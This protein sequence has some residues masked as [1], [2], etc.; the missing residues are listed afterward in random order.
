M[1]A[2]R[3]CSAT[4]VVS[5]HTPLRDA[6]RPV[7]VLA[8]EDP[9]AAV[10]DA[11]RA[12]D[13]LLL[14]TSGTSGRPRGV[15]RTAASWAASFP[16]VTSL[17]GLTAASR[18]WVPGPLTATM[19][20]FAAVHG[21]HV[22]AAAVDRPR[23]ATHA[24]LTPAALDRS[25]ADPLPVG[26]TVLVAG[27]GLGTRLHDRAAAAGLRVAH[28]YG[29]AELSFVAWGSHSGDLR[30]FPGVEVRARDGVLW[31]RSPYLARGYLGDP[32]PFEI[33]PDGFGTVGDLGTV[34]HG[35]VTVHGRGDDAITTAG[36]T[37]LVA[38][39]ERVL[40]PAAAG[41]LV[42]VAAPHPA[43]GAVVACVLTDRS[44]Q[45]RLAILARD[46]LAPA[47]RPRLWF[48]LPRLPVGPHGKVD[49]PAVRQLVATGA[50]S[51]MA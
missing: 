18:I 26:A 29:A 27:D 20:L 43:L 38:D 33:G 40:G 28:Y 22:G 37:V 47:P 21:A 31:V 2:I 7:D 23:D 10:L 45:R 8:A 5:G 1:P 3:G 14:R 9:V 51:R 36:T 12:G 41:E 6:G 17:L 19:N 13:S 49:R 15:L 30:P 4:R 39:V 16:A 46:R 11:V 34:Q 48:H 42:V 50:L 44:D 35:R 32:G 24:V 25:L